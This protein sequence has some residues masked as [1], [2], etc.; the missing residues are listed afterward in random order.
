M[1]KKGSSTWTRAIMAIQLHEFSNPHIVA[2]LKFKVRQSAL[3]ILLLLE[4]KR[5][6]ENVTNREIVRILIDVSLFLAQGVLAFRGHRESW[7]DTNN[8]S[9]F[10]NLVSMLAK[11]SPCLAAYSAK[12]QSSGKGLNSVLLYQFDKTN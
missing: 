11:Y 8:K 2:S 9:N 1:D 6:Q 7:S 12:K 5:K 4:D 10:L 3:H